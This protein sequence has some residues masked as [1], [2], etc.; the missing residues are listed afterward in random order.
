MAKKPEQDKSDGSWR[1]WEW[2]G[3][4]SEQI[5]QKNLF[6]KQTLIRKVNMNSRIFKKLKLVESTEVDWDHLF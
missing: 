4:E 3:L 1:I 5:V 6:F 2:G